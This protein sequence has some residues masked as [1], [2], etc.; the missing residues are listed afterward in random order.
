MLILSVHRATTVLGCY[1]LH[2]INDATVNCPLEKSVPDVLD[3][4]APGQ[5]QLRSQYDQ[6]EI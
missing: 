5:R 2:F 3:V 1:T 4:G 6:L